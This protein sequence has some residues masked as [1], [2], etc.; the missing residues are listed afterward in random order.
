M[1]GTL[2]SR[3]QDYI[4][5]IT[6]YSGLIGLVVNSI[7]RRLTRDFPY[8]FWVGFF[9]FMISMIILLMRQ[10]KVQKRHL[11]GKN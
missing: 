8:S 2:T 9:A 10:F 4:L 3:N 5:E 6:I 11:R 7:T 1:D